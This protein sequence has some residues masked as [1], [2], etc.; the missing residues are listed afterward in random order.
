MGKKVVAVGGDDG[1]NTIFKA[2]YR[3]VYE[4]LCRD[5]AVMRRRSDAYLNATQI[6][7][8]AGF[9]KPQRTRVLEREVQKGEHE[10]VQGGY[11]KYQGTWIPIERG[12]ALAKQYGVEDLLR[13][14]IDYVPTSVSPPP[15]PKHAV[16]PPTKSRKEKESKAT[17]EQSTPSK[18]GP[19]S[20]AALQ[21]Q[22]QLAASRNKRTPKQESTPDIDVTL[23][24]N[25]PDESLSVT[26]EGGE[27]DESSSQTPSP[28]ASEL[29]L[30][31]ERPEQTMDVDGMEMSMNMGGVPMGLSHSHMDT[32][33]SASRKR[34]AAMMMDEDQDQYAQL[35]RIR[36]NSAVHTPQGSPR[37]LGM[38]LN[39]E[40][41]VGP[42]GYT[43]MILNYFVSETT[44]IP[45]ILV[46]PPHDYDP[47]SR[48]DDDGHTAL[49]WACAMGRVR[50]VKLLL[51]AGA[52][53]FAGNN[54]EQT[55]LMRAVMFSN[56]YDMRKF[57]EL[58]ELLHRSTLNI[59]KQNRTVFHHIANLALSKGK[60]HAAK[61]YMETILS[62]LADYPQELADVINFQDEE[63]ETA[64]TVAARARS[65]R[66][67]KALLDHGADPKI[68][69]RDFKSAEDYILEDERFRSSP[70]QP[71]GSGG[72]GSGGQNANATAGPS[73]KAVFAPQL[74]S[75]EAARLAGG[76]SLQDIT[77]HMQSLA[78]SF[79]SE[80][81]GKERDILQAKAM[82][83]S[84]H[85]EV[86]AATKAIAS[87]NEKAGPIEEQ[88]RESEHL[89]ANLRSKVSQALKKGF[90]AWLAGEQG[91]EARWR[92][93]EAGAN[94]E[95]VR[96]LEETNSI[97]AGG[98]EVV[99]AEEERLRWEIE[100]KRRRRYELVDRFVKAQ[101]ES[102]TSEQIAKYRRLIA[103]G[104]GGATASEVDDVMAQLL[105]T[106]ENETQ[107]N[108][109]SATTTNTGS[110]TN[111]NFN[112]PAGPGAGVGVGVGVGVGLDSTTWMS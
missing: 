101:T 64:L 23:R 93:G 72:G 33:A 4:M 91:R 111:T 106:L 94:G 69:N 50:V 75:S 48:I 29:D 13:P 78:R 35:R 88:K 34:N 56:N 27:G 103:A 92:S 61:Y 95:D 40:P 18:T 47:N 14:I 39:D 6:L 51:T 55:P 59:D 38:G 67:V 109:F 81:Q 97:P 73:D 45:Q 96:D 37:H 54:A 21:A 25:E 71:N 8:V 53:I 66:L 62:R 2:T 83:T 80:L 10:K 1:P 68:K 89:Q 20:A 3:P 63:G 85:T 46:S 107:Q 12:L 43:D 52:S 5:V 36:G 70:V 108:T 42:E 7:K 102:G 99:Q 28:V 98:Q 32:L 44:Q 31:P 22:A 41:P 74:Y 16:A 112:V 11:G 84:I 77:T 79:D 82:L 87:L 65:R 100:E 57:P 90:E 49:H 110:N 19:T 30:P 58:Y 104:C 9:D 105:E 60:T 86:T 24:S 15:A 26:P 17:K 76:Q